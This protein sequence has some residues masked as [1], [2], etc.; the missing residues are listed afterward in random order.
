MSKRIQKIEQLDALRAIAAFCVIF[1]HFL[2]E[3]KIGNFYYGWIGVDL[4]FVISGYLITAILLEQ[5]DVIN[6]KLLIIKNFIIKRALR[7]FPTYYI[8]ITFFL[9]LMILFNLYVWDKGDSIYYYTYTQNI[10]F[11]KEDMKGIQ[12]QH[13]WTLAVEEQFYLVWPWIVIYIG[14]PNLI[15]LLLII[16]PATLIFKSFS[17]IEH[18]RMLTPYHFDTLGTGALVALLVKQKKDYYLIAFNR[19][20]TVLILLSLGTL[21]ASL[22]YKLPSLATYS[23]I[24]VLSTSFLVDCFYNFKGILGT[25]LNNPML[26]YLGKISY[27]L[28]LFHKPIPYFVNMIIKKTGFHINAYFL[29]ILS[30]FATVLIAHVSFK[31]IEKRFLSLKVKYDL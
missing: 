7:L 21:T 12:L 5:K 1:Y 15:R 31:L 9:L 23:A 17:H 3:Y 6:N 4:F 13:L 10:L 29:L 14:N 8:L 24:V 28:Y 30:L 11:F 2:P 27:G 18:I 22:F 16:I 25:A 20:K 26:T 19:L